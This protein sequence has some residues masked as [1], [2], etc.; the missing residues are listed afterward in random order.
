MSGN[1]QQ[2]TYGQD[3]AKSELRGTKAGSAGVRPRP[4]KKARLVRH[5]PFLL[6]RCL[7][8]SLTCPPGARTATAK[9][10]CP[11]SSQRRMR[12]RCSKL[13]V[14]A[15][16][17][18]SLGTGPANRPPS[19]SPSPPPPTHAEWA[20]GLRHTS[21]GC[22]KHLSRNLF[23]SQILDRYLTSYIHPPIHPS[24]L[25]FKAPLSISSTHHICR[26]Y[27]AIAHN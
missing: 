11:S 1:V 26:P 10:Q 13:D 18:P 12:D 6:A 21:E 2:G 5:L 22:D 20:G 16:P 14:L 27:C 25:I 4:I 8:A 23:P 9:C 7:L 3:G 15:P 17:S 24:Y 19:R